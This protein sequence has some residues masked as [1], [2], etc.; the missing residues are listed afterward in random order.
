MNEIP[1]NQEPREETA[2]D[3]PPEAPAHELRVRDGKKG[4]LFCVTITYYA[5]DHRQELKL[6]EFRNL[7]WDEWLT[8]RQDIFVIGFSFRESPGR[9]RLVAP[10]NVHEVFCDRQNGY[11]S[12]F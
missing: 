6:K 11:F 2:Q 4:M 12:P 9:Y 5:G 8:I 3:A 7:Y 1:N 10:G